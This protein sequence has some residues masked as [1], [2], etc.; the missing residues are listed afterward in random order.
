MISIM[1]KSTVVGL[2]TVLSVLV[3][4]KSHQEVRSVARGETRGESV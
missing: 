2:S 4:R 3:G 1:V